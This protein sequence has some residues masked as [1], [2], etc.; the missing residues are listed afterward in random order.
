MKKTP[1]NPEQLAIVNLTD[2]EKTYLRRP[3]RGSGGFQ[4]LLTK[5]RDST[6]KGI[7]SLDHIL[8]SDVV[9]YWENYGH[10]G[11]QDRLSSISNAARSLI[12]REELLDKSLEAYI[13]SLETINRLSIKY[14]VE[15]FT[16]L[17]CNAWELLLKARILQS[18]NNEAS[19]D[20]KKKKHPA[21]RY[22]L[23]LEKCLNT[24]FTS[25]NE[26]VKDNIFKV[27]ELR[28][29]ATHLCISHI[30]PRMLGLFQSCVLDYHESLYDWFGISLSD[31]VPVGMMTI[32]Y[33]YQLDQSKA[34]LAILRGKMN[35][36]TAEYIVQYEAQI[37]KRYEELGKSNRYYMKITTPLEIK[38]KITS[39]QDDD[40]INGIPIDWDK[41]H[42][43]Q[44]KEVVEYIDKY[45]KG[46]LRINTNIMTCI[47]LANDINNRGKFYY[48]SDA[49]GAPRQFSPEFVEWLKEQIDKDPQFFDKCT[50]IVYKK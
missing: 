7:M 24:V 44:Q 38:V 20:D 37:Q 8:A 23:G 17:I 6:K 28:N 30:P 4:S 3:I 36:A 42:P 11:F 19:I 25:A 31:K 45:T 33:D 9:R 35:K 49:R 2:D 29:D 13:L 46:K 16:F 27:A 39:A 47:L 32:A 22:T 1:F 40:A 5:L 14:R 41:T 10:G 43:L 21:K 15:S 50:T 18:T 26:P 34:D 12:L 48:K